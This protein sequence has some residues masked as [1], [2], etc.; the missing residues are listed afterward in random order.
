MNDPR[1]ALATWRDTPTRKAI[2]TFVEAVSTPGSPSFVRPAERIA[3]FDNDG[4][5][6]CEKPMPIELG[7]ILERFSEMAEA[8]ADLRS[9]QPW[10]AASERDYA[11]L[12]EA[13][14]KHYQ[15]DDRDVKLLIG[16][17]V[18]AF[19][20]QTVEDYGAAADAYLRG[21]S[22]PTLQR[23]Y[24]DCSFA[25]M[26]DLLS[27]LE[28]NGFTNYI[29]SGGDRDFMRPVTGD[30]YGIP[31]ERVVGSSNALEYLE[32]E[33]G[34][35]V[36]YGAAPDVF[37]DGAAKPV[38]IWSRIGRRPLIAAGNSNG[39]IEMLNF[40]GGRDREALRILINHDDAER[41]FAY[42]AGAERSLEEAAKQGWTVVNIKDDWAT[43]FA[44]TAASTQRAA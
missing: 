35:V 44:D 4:T 37:D 11:W 40:A 8:D 31:P 21:S 10:K 42:T 25:P 34:S 33:R 3:V 27:Y 9:R 23:I 26:L 20:G 6:W 13:M 29:A 12:G 5:L 28:A 36:V 41:E 43:V 2:T 32:D 38:R 22:H 30:V 19:A 39:D 24:C 7:F 17:V 16:G 14:T 15:G 1:N 18:K